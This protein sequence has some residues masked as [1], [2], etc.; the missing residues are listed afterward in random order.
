MMAPISTASRFL[1]LCT[2]LLAALAVPA[3]AQFGGGGLG[4]GQK[5][6]ARLFTRV[7]GDEIR[8][9]IEVKIERAWHLYHDDLGHPEAIGQPTVVTFDAAGVEWSPVRF[10]EPHPYDQS[11]I[12]SPGTFINGHEGTIVLYAAGSFSGAEPEEIS[13]SIKGL[14]CKDDGACIPYRQTVA[15][16]GAGADALFANFPEDLEPGA[17]AAGT[18]PASGGSSGGDESGPG[19]TGT[20]TVGA[21]TTGAG[22]AR[23]EVTDEAAIAGAIASFPDFNPQG[24]VSEHSLA[25]WL[26]LA[27]IAGMILNVMPCVLPVISIKVLSFVQQAGEDRKRIFQLGV[28]FAAGIVVVFFALAAL[29]IT[30]GLSWGEQFQSEGFLI[31]MIGIVFAF[32]LSLFG[33]FEVGVP[34]QVGS[35]GGIAREGLGDAFFKGMLATVLATPC[36]GPFLGS[37]LTWTLAQPP[38]VVF[39]IFASLG[40]GMAFPY[41]VLTAN[42][43]LL[44]LLPKP[45][46]WMETFKQAMGFVLLVTVIYLMISLRQDVLLFTAAFLVFVA[47]GCW[48]WGRFAKFDQSKV[49]RTGHLA[50]ALGICVMGARISFVDFQGLFSDVESD[51][52][53]AWIDYDTES[54]LGYL[55]DDRTVFVDFTADWC[56]NCKYNEKF[57]FNSPEVRALIAEKNV[58]PIKADITH[59]S[60]VKEALRDKLGGSS[61]PYLAVFPGDNTS[62]P[63]VLPDVVTVAQMVEIFEACPDP[64]VLARR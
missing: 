35:M 30:A 19:T 4:G 56:P 6:S 39:L 43:A 58:V 21:G 29:A 20:G 10:P 18:E 15:A 37:T 50:V 7:E 44:K 31:T 23:P 53:I 22:S 38:H 9:A 8:A 40:L 16:A 11:D 14:T 27:F 54:F 61:I 59:D 13:V 5:A 32:A 25:I 36:S 48:W 63:F 62:A 42:P 47:G 64:G 60:P 1:A 34:A 33:V 24:E 52:R 26:L 2:L 12:A 45:G 3:A 51:D 49:V 55:E 57:V 28:A 46:A 17:E 41:V